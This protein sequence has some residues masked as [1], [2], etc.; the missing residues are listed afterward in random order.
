[1]HNDVDSIWEVVTG[2]KIWSTSGKKER[3]KVGKGDV[4]EMGRGDEDGEDREKGGDCVSVFQ[5]AQT[6]LWVTDVIRFPAQAVY[7]EMKWEVL[8]TLVSVNWYGRGPWNDWEIDFS[9]EFD[10]WLSSGD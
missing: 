10:F 6:S 1:M 7:A 3:G 8:G 2:S 4:E 9:V 5:T